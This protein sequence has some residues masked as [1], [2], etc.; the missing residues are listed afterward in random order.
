MSG[1]APERILLYA[2]NEAIIAAL[3]VLVGVLLS[4]MFMVYDNEMTYR[5]GQQVGYERAMSELV[6]I[7]SPDTP[8][9]H[10]SVPRSS[11]EGL[12]NAGVW[13]WPDACEKESDDG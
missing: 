4:Q 10:V 3:G 8:K 2:M 9:C 13:L 1:E 12:V 6:D 7:G 11:L 5:E